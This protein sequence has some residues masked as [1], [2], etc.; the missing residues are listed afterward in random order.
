MRLLV[1]E[2]D[3]WVTTLLRKALEGQGYAVDS[4]DSGNDALCMARSASY[5]AVVLDVGIPA[6]DGLEVTRQLRAGKCWTPILLLTGREQIEDRVAGLDA[7]ADDYLAKPFAIEELHARLRALTRRAA[8]DRPSVLEAGDLVLDPASH[9]VFRGE[10]EIELTA[11]EFALL[12]LLMRHK[13]QVLTRP[14]ILDH[15]WDLAYEWASNVIDVHIRA[16]RTKI[17]KPFG[18][19]TIETVRGVG[20]RLR[21]CPSS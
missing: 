13:G 19:A 14:M 2:D 7:G 20:Y 17:D 10:V 9:Q 5:G 15:L 16:L 8:V 3:P 21:S 11:R 18:T 6:P 4:V 1:V 12:E